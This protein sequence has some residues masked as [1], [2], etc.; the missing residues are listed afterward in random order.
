MPRDHWWYEPWRLDFLDLPIDIADIYINNKLKSINRSVRESDKK[1]S[2]VRSWSCQGTRSKWGA[3]LHTDHLSVTMVVRVY[4]YEVFFLG[5]WFPGF[6]CPIMVLPLKCW[7]VSTSSTKIMWCW[8]VIDLWWFQ[9]FITAVFLIDI[10]A[11]YWFLVIIGITSP[12]CA[13][14]IIRLNGKATQQMLDIPIQ[15]HVVSAF[16]PHPHQ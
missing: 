7:K 16:S 5:N 2:P 3:C 6:G 10:F 1:D 9:I 12:C 15:L 11:A 4:E 8:R 13:F 14:L